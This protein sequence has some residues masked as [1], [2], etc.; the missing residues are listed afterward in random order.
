MYFEEVLLRYDQLIKSTDKDTILMLESVFQTINTYKEEQFSKW[1]HLTKL[2]SHKDSHIVI[3]KLADNFEEVTMKVHLS[4]LE[5]GIENHEFKVKNPKALAKM[6]SMLLI[7]LY[8]KINLIVASPADEELVSEYKDFACFLEDT[9][10]ASIED[11][12]RDLDISSPAFKY[13]ELVLE[14]IKSM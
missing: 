14:K 9:V 5:K 2:Y 7:E 8:S 1:D 12:S 3:R 4:L 6:W 11:K 10:N 13:L